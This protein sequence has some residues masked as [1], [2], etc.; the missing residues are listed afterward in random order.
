LVNSLTSPISQSYSST[1]LDM[2]GFAHGTL[3]TLDSGPVQVVL[4]GEYERDILGSPSLSFKPKRENDSG[5]TEVKIP[6]LS[7]VTGGHGGDLVSLSGAMRYDNYSDFGAHVSVG[8]GAEARPLQSLLLRASYSSAF[9]PPLLVSLYAPMFNSTF[10][11]TD[12]QLGGLIYSAPTVAGGNTNLRP[13]T[14]QARTVGFV[15]SPDFVP[16]LTLSISNWENRIK[17]GFTAPNAQFLVSNPNFFPGRVVRDPITNKITLLDLRSINYGHIY[18]AGFDYRLGWS[19]ETS[20]GEFSPSLSVSQTYK[21]KIQVTPTSLETNNVSI[22]STTG[23]A[24]RW[25]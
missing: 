7:D 14:G 3:L 21:Y 25:K 22:S 6:I 10:T 5:F 17:N 8:A 11:V 2:T 4:G 18:E 9:K 1:L 12:P 19:T 16:G 15:F 23:F 20:F 13:E 24:P